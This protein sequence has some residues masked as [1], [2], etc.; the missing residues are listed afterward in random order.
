[1]G[2]APA[3][4]E[5]RGGRRRGCSLP[6][7]AKGLDQGG[8]SPSLQLCAPGTAVLLDQLLPMASSVGVVSLYTG[9]YQSAGD[10]P[11]RRM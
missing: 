8:R 11:A 4:R 6:A 10:P 1:M 2:Q 7:G 5:A 9:P 3:W